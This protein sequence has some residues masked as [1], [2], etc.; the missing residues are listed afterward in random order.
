M[1]SIWLAGLCVLALTQ[2]ADAQN[3]PPPPPPM[4]A[5]PIAV[6][7]PPFVNGTS[8]ADDVRAKLGTPEKNVPSDDGRFTYVYTLENGTRVAIFRFGKDG[9]LFNVGIYAR[10]P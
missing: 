4:A 8:T 9:I 7:M 1:R 10:T 5:Q 6:S 3:G 2:M